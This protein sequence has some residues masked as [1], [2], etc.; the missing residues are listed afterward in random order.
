MKLY[1]DSATALGPYEA[2]LR[3][4]VYR[5]KRESGE[6][7]AEAMAKLLIAYRH[8]CLSQWA[9]TSVVP[10]P[11][12]WTRRLVRRTN[13]PE[14]LAGHISRQLGVHVEPKILYRCRNTK[15]QR[16][17]LP[18][19]RFR[20][21]AGAFAVRPGISLSGQN[22]LLVDDVMT[23]GATANEAARVLKKAGAAKVLVAVIARAQGN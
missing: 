15:L 19:E 22:I 17:L 4:I 20:N 6:P 5:M 12:F 1:F 23:T 18:R 14:V 13:N 2:E 7:F 16:E 11:M 8:D 9:C 21:V 3:E 10:I